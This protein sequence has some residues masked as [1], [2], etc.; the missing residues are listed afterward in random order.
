[1]STQSTTSSSVTSSLPISPPPFTAGPRTTTMQDVDDSDDSVPSSR[2]LGLC[3]PS[4]SPSPPQI[5]YW[6]RIRQPLPTQAEAFSLR[7][8]YASPPLGSVDLGSL[9]DRMAGFMRR[10]VVRREHWR[11][12]SPSLG[13]P[14]L[15]NDRSNS[16]Q[17]NE[18]EN[19]DNHVNNANLDS[20][21]H[22]NAAGP[23]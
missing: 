16:N 2:Q 10:E 19:E 22:D 14:S 18:N 3:T 1:M 13:P 23:R 8:M 6:G 7:H 20:R 4:P 11:R 15:G 9:N 17:E 21:N 12:W 5:G